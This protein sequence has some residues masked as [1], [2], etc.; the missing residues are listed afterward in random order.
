MMMKAARIH[1]YGDP[2]IVETVPRPAVT[3]G[4]ILI[5]IIASG[6][7]HTDLHV[8]AGEMQ[9]SPKLPFI[10]G[11]EIIGRVAEIG[12]SVDGFKEGD[13]VGL[14]SLH[15]ACGECEFC[16]S[17]RESLCHKQLATGYSVD[18]G[19]AEFVVAQ[20]KFVARV[21]EIV[22]PYQ[23]APVLCAGVT[24]YKALK[25]A[26]VTHGEWIVVS[27]IGG[28]GHL[29][30]QYALAMGY[31]VAAVDIANDKLDLARKLGVELSINA[32]TDDPVEV[33]NKEISGAHAVIVTASSSS[34]FRS[35]IGMLRRGGTT[36][37]CGLPPGEFLFPIA[38]VVL[39][40]QT[41]R[42]SIIGSR[43]DLEEAIE[44]AIAHK[45]HIEIQKRRLEEIND[46]FKELGRGEVTGRVVLDMKS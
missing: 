46:I 33:I 10:P 43:T 5:S 30:I 3:D 24:T 9:G 29:A 18:G 32:A 6:V 8:C 4:K 41:I 45:F 28:L 40:G 20:A 27:G 19:F 12:R 11:H 38:D 31:N 17:G 1:R 21:P 2:L 36:V 42:G 39:A 14:A 22:D 13:L 16:T 34:A 7:C 23:F 25:I 26:N 35:S 44:F 37:L 15:W